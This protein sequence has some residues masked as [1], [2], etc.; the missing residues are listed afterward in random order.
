MTSHYFRSFTVGGLLR[1][2]FLKITGK[3]VLVVGKCHQCGTCCRSISIEG[4]KGWLRSEKDFSTIVDKQPEYARFTI[5][6]RDSYG[7]LLFQCT[8]L[9]DQNQCLNYDKRLPLCDKYPESSLVFMGAKSPDGC[10]YTYKTAVPFEK[11]LKNE[12]KKRK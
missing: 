1:Y 3:S 10:G 8:W 4:P 7:F 9:T 11:Y 6:G 2:F 12:M 5:I